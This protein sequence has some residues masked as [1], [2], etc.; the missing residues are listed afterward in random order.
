MLVLDGFNPSLALATTMSRPFCLPSI[1]LCPAPMC[2][3]CQLGKQKRRSTESRHI[4]APHKMKLKENALVPGSAFHLDL[5]QSAVKGRLP[6]TYGK[7]KPSDKYS[8][9]LIAVDAA[10]GFIFVRHQVSLRAGE[11]IQS[12]RTFASYAKSFGIRLGTLRADNQPFDSALFRDYVDASD[13][14]DITLSGV[15][16]HHQNAVAERAIGTVTSWA[17]TM[18]L[19]SIIHW[20]DAAS[21]DLWPYA[22]DYAAMIW[23]HLPKHDTKLAPIEIFTGSRLPNYDFLHRCH[24]WG[25]PTYVLDPKLQDGTKIPKWSPRARRGLFLGFSPDHS[26]TVARILSLRTGAFSPQFHCVFDDLFTTVP[27]GGNGPLVDTNRFDLDEWNRL[28]STGYE[29]YSE[30]TPLHELP[31]LDREFLPTAPSPSPPRPAPAPVPAPVSVP[32]PAAS[33]PPPPPPVPEGDSTPVAPPIP[34]SVSEGEADVDPALDDFEASDPPPDD[35]V[36]PSPRHPPDPTHES[37][38]NPVRRSGRTRR[39]PRRLIEE[40]A[41][42]IPTPKTPFGNHSYAYGA[43]PSQR[44]PCGLYNQQFLCISNCPTSSQPQRLKLNTMVYLT[45]CVKLF[46]F[47]ILSSQSL[48]MLDFPRPRLQLFALL[49]MKTTQ[50]PYASRT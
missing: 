3:A 39:P 4:F 37:S 30:H 41:T 35:P 27:S 22:M 20:P 21:L 26:T 9:G 46:R 24:V 23:N 34:A 19:H 7:E 14:T 12:L 13:F 16:A 47:K 32:A 45:L 2:A 44:V 31:S 18:L 49:F 8:G 50:P 42:S 33:P 17:R 25:C 43:D 28:I 48:P 36:I 10:S 11:T 6:T 40:C 29:R 38:P 1:L 5:Y 15:G